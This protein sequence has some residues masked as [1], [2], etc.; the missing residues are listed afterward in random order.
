M[1]ALLYIIRAVVRLKEPG[2]VVLAGTASEGASLRVGDTV[3]LRLADGSST[4]TKVKAFPLINPH[5][6]EWQ[7]PIS[8]PPEV[9]EADVPAGT[10]V[11]SYP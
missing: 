2:L 1:G 6:H 10:G 11:W 9:S 4:L 7:V 8:F 5:D 3:E